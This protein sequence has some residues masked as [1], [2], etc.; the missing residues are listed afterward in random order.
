MMLSNNRHIYLTVFAILV[1]CGYTTTGLLAQNQYKIAIDWSNIAGTIDSAHWGV[2]DYEIQEP[3]TAADPVFVDFMQKIDPAFIRIHRSSLSDRYTDKDTETWDSAY[4]VTCFDS[5]KMAYGDAKIMFNPMPQ[6]PDWMDEPNVLTPAGEDKV[7]MLLA[8]IA[9]IMKNSGIHIDYWEIFNERDN[10]YEDDNALDRYFALY[11]RAYDTI[12]SVLPDAKIGGLAFTHPKYEWITGFLDQCA[13]KYDFISW[14]NYSNGAVN[15]PNDSVMVVERPGSIVSQA[16]G[17][18]NQLKARGLENKIETF[19]TEYNIQWTWD[20]IEER[21][22]NHIG[23]MFQASVISRLA[24]LNLTG[25]AVWHNKGNAYGLINSKNEM[26]A[27]GIMYSWG[28]RYLAGERVAVTDAPS[29]NKVEVIPVLNHSNDSSILFLNKSYLA[30][31]IPFDSLKMSKNIRILTLDESSYYA[32]PLNIENDTLTLPPMSATLVTTQPAS[33]DISPAKPGLSGFAQLT[34]ITLN[35]S[36]LSDETSFAG[37]KLFMNDTFHGFFSGVNTLNISALEMGTA[38]SFKAIS[39]DEEGNTSEPSDVLNLVT[40]TDTTGPTI[41]S[42]LKSEII[43]ENVVKFTWNPSL[44]NSGISGYVIVINGEV[45]DTVSVTEYVLD[46]TSYN[47]NVIFSVYAFDK[48]GNNSEKATEEIA[49]SVPSLN[50][51]E[52]IILYPNPLFQS[53]Q[54]FIQNR[55]STLEIKKVKIFDSQGKEVPVQIEKTNTKRIKIKIKNESIQP[56]VYYIQITN[57]N[58]YTITTKL[59]IN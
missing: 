12:K 19:L 41:P 30:T 32:Y 18:I 31:Q 53:S 48:Y 54:F 1:L 21:H 17:V 16:E 49:V 58:T 7:I 28:N 37:F 13:G 14:H 40:K 55:R 26:R 39:T 46:Y 15:K 27:T 43:D 56:G 2:A 5:A 24:A 47:S 44:D 51:T 59:L 50:I 38:Y 3:N 57:N 35:I 42:R 33:E 34:G 23:A 36:N 9:Q 25:V 10:E 11:N 22:G 8:E 20:P 29:R 45:I 4:I 52:D 6:W